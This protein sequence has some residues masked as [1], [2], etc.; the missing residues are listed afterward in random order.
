M[1]GLAEVIASAFASG[2][3]AAGRLGGREVFCPPSDLGGKQIM[4]AL[5]RFVADNPDL[6]DEPYGLAMAASLRDTFPCQR[7]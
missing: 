7:L 4:S 1:R 5:E 2:L 3:V 6:A